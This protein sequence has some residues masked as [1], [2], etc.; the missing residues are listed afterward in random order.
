MNSQEDFIYI[1]PEQDLSTIVKVLNLSHGTIARDFNFTKEDNPTN[2]AFI[3]EKTLR[4]QLNN[5]IELYGLKMNNRL[6]GCIAIEKSKREPSTYY[7]EKVSVLP[8]FRHQGIGVRLMDFAT[9][10]IKDAGGQIIS[11]ALI[12]SNT[13][14]K[15]WYLSQGFIE[16]GFK[17]FEHLPFRVCFM[18]KE[19]IVQS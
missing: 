12:D 13:K 6:V 7:I 4:E 14:L 5:G 10:K 8:E 18:R 3:D 11:I 16:T 1:A 2:N 15:K 19:S 17:D 9:A